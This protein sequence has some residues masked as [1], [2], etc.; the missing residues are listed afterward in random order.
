MTN[1]FILITSPRLMN[2]AYTVL[3]I[4]LT[5]R[6]MHACDALNPA[7]FKIL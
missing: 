7:V 6:Y 5:P 1:I 4:I 3:C 2:Y